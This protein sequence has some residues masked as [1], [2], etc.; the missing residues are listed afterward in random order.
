M[1]GGKF[2]RKKQDEQNRRLYHSLLLVV[3]PALWLMDVTVPKHR[4]GGFGD[5]LFLAQTL[6]AV[7]G[8][9]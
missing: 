7:H 9:C 4:K 1:L 8:R 2:I 6:F 5:F 3:G